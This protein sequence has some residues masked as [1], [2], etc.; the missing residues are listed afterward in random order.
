MTP[1]RLKWSYFLNLKENHGVAK[2]YLDLYRD[3]LGWVRLGHPIEKV[4]W[5]ALASSTLSKM[6]KDPAALLASLAG[7]TFEGNYRVALYHFYLGELRE[8]LRLRKQ[9]E[10]I[11]AEL[12]QNIQ[13]FPLAWKD[14]HSRMVS[15]I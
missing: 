5:W 12:V 2:V 15:E 3:L 8:R 11:Q 4:N 14:G 10:I 9:L 1:N 13:R 6:L 7:N